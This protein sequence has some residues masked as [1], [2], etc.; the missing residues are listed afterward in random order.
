MLRIESDGAS[1]GESGGTA[2]GESDPEMVERRSLRSATISVGS[3]STLI[4]VTVDDGAD[5]S[6][7]GSNHSKQFADILVPIRFIEFRVANDNVATC[8]HFV[9]V[10]VTLPTEVGQVT[11]RR[12]RIYVADIQMSEMLL[13]RPFLRRL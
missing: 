9:L 3:V 2:P 8:S 5:F 11:V 12:H 13:G 4:S 6:L 1:L 10:D 7:M